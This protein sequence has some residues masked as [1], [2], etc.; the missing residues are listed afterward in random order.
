MALA[1]IASQV[2]VLV[3]TFERPR[4]LDRLVRSIRRFCPRL[5]VIVG[6]DSITAYPRA[7]VD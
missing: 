2:T 3:K 5:R 7:D 6:D 1:G 4:S